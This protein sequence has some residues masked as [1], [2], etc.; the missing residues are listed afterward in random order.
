MELLKRAWVGSAQIHLG[1]V[2][3]EWREDD[4]WEFR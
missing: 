2:D 1:Q 4:V 3:V